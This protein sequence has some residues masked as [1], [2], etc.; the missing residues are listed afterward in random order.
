MTAT[1]E[2]A[3]VRPGILAS[4]AI[5]PSPAVPLG[6]TLDTPQTLGDL[7]KGDQLSYGGRWHRVVLVTGVNGWVTVRTGLY[8]PDI[9]GWSE[10]PVIIARESL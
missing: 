7:R 1:E 2:R 6:F 8:S 10:M 5:E 9:D 4:L 3:P